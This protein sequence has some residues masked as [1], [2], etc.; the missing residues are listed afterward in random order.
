M[1][2]G[3]S[4][5]SDIALEL[6]NGLTNSDIKNRWHGYLKESSGIIK[7]AVQA[8]Q[9]KSHYLD[10]GCRCNNCENEVKGNHNF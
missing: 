10:C 3:C 6:G 1:F 7:P 9:K 5:Y 4:S 8:G 2:G